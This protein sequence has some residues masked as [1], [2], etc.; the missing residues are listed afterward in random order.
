METCDH[1]FLYSTK[2]ITECVKCGFVDVNAVVPDWAHRRKHD[3]ETSHIAARKKDTRRNEVKT[4]EIIRTYGAKGCIR[5]EIFRDFGVEEGIPVS[6]GSAQGPCTDLRQKF[7]IIYLEEKRTGYRFNMPQ[8]VMRVTTEREKERLQ[9][10]WDAN[11]ERYER[12]LFANPSWLDRWYEADRTYKL[13]KENLE[14]HKQFIIDQLGLEITTY[15]LRVNM[16]Q[17]L[18][19][20]W[21]KTDDKEFTLRNNKYKDKK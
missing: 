5:D 6:E 16:D 21:K 9:A 20:N 10:S 12:T 8:I 2:G 15:N 19:I 7:L 18:R 3:L 11:C 17:I 13:A 1:D 14:M 4:Y